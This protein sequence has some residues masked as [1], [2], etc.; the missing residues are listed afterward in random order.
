MFPLLNQYP[1]RG[2]QSSVNMCSH[3]WYVSQTDLHYHI[4][5]S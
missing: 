4:D 2:Q 3:F 5:V 1:S